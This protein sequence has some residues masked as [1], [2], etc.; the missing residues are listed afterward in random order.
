M[1]IFAIINGTLRNQV[2]GPKVTELLA[3]QLS[4]VIYI[5]VF[6]L[7]MVLLFSQTNA[8]YTQ[9]DLIII[10]I[11]WLT[12]TVLFEFGFGHYVIGHSWSRLIHDYNIFQGRIWALVLITELIGPYIIG[13]YFQ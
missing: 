4:T 3:H 9:K 13:R 10:G 1:L 12:L 6:I 5:V 8:P 2:Y 7:V 11:V